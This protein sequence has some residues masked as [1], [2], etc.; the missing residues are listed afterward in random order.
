MYLIYYKDQTDKFKCEACHLG[1]TKTLQRA[2]K[3]E[4]EGNTIVCVFSGLGRRIK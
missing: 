2:F 1:E 4:T 3:L